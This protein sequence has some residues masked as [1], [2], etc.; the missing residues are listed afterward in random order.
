[1]NSFF[2]VFI[3][4]LI[5][6]KVNSAVVRDAF[7]DEREDETDYDYYDLSVRG[8]LKDPNNPLYVG[9]ITTTTTTSNLPKI[10]LENYI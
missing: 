3:A 6:V 8:A 4:C 2:V 7:Y 1:M 9:N 10:C 5:I